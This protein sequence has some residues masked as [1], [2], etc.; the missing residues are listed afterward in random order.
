MCCQ[1]A[2]VHI[3]LKY[4]FLGGNNFN[5]ADIVQIF[6]HFSDLFLAYLW[7]ASE[8]QSSWGRVP[9]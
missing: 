2:Y 6:L 3:Y 1:L 4:E 7:K 8:L 5:D 9:W